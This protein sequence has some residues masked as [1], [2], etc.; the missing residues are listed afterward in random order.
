MTY[1]GGGP[2]NAAFQAVTPA[3]TQT[4]TGKR[5]VYTMEFISAG[6]IT[7]SGAQDGST[8]EGSCSY[9]LQGPV[10][11]AGESLPQTFANVPL[12]EYTLTFSSG[13]P[14]GSELKGISPSAVQ[15]V[16]YAQT[17]DYVLDFEAKGQITVK[18][19]TYT[20]DWAGACS[21]VINGPVSLTGT[22]LPFT[23]TGRPDGV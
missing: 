5:L 6:S 22:E 13:G 17:T 18:G 11:L 21:Y 12:G 7:V 14:D 9:T 10:T 2:E 8:W 23:F 3:V 4:M 15:T 20:A 1:G 19:K 16:A